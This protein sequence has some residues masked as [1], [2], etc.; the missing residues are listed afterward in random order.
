MAEPADKIKDAALKLLRE[1]P[2]RAAIE[3]HR[4]WPW[5]RRVEA[6]LIKLDAE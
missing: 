2:T 4:Y 5:K 3:H 6:F 1:A